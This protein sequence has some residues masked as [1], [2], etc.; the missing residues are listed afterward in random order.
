M[1]GKVVLDLVLDAMTEHKK[2]LLG[3]LNRVYPD[4][5]E[6]YVE[7]LKSFMFTDMCANYLKPVKNGKFLVF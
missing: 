2:G 3:F 6:E 7:R 1:V 5:L 4:A